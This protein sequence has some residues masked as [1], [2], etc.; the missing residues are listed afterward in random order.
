MVISSTVLKIF[1]NSDLTFTGKLIVTFSTSSV[2]SSTT[3]TVELYDKYVSGSDY[4]RSVRVQ[5]TITNNPGYTIL[6]NTNIKWRRM[7]YRQL[8]T[9]AAPLRLTLNNNY[10][11][12]SVYS[13]T[14]NS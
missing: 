13:T 8:R 11:Y 9:D 2:P 7:A 4:G 5:Q 14:S 10:Q 12:V 1:S 3:I 6:A